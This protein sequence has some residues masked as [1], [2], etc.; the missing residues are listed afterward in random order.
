[1]WPSDLD[2]VGV[3]VALLVVLAY[4]SFRRRTL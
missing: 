3:A 1:M 2:P 4:R